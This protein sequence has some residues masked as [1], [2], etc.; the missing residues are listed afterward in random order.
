[1]VK[2]KASDVDIANVVNNVAQACGGDLA[3]VYEKYKMKDEFRF[4]LIMNILSF[5][6]DMLSIILASAA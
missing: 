2:A 3:P 1:M 5:V 6:H 4:A